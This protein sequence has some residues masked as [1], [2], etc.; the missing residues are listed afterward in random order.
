MGLVDVALPWN[1]RDQEHI[2]TLAVKNIDVETFRLSEKFEFGLINKGT[3][4]FSCFRKSIDFGGRT[5]TKITAKRNAKNAVV[6]I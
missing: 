4:Y 6:W 5:R 1:L 2:R 3:F